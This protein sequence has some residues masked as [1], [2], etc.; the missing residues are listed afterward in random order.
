MSEVDP[1]VMKP[2]NVIIQWEPP[3]IEVQ[4]KVTYLGVVAANP[5][6]YQRKFAGQLLDAKDIP[7]HLRDIKNPQGLVLAADVQKHH[8]A[9]LYGD[10]NA[11]LDVDLE[12]E[13]LLEY[14]AQIMALVN[15]H[16][17]EYLSPSADIEKSTTLVVK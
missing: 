11:L 5:D 14:K 13:D 1:K 12:K 8:V 16:L 17:R 9:E 6:E 2:K 15:S 4:R 7:Q 10:V 3:K